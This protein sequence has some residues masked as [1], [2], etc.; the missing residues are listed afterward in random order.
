METRDEV[1]A[2]VG[3]RLRFDP[4]TSPSHPPVYGF[5]LGT[6]GQEFAARAWKILQSDRGTDGKRSRHNED[7]RLCHG[8]GHE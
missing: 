1:G 8:D 2:W 4:S 5:P 3:G 7:A 6:N